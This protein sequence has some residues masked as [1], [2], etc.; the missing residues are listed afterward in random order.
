M[1][2]WPLGLFIGRRGIC[3]LCLGISLLLSMEV[4]VGLCGNS[5]IQKRLCY[6]FLSVNKVEA[7]FL[8]PINLCVTTDVSIL[9]VYRVE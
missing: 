1:S 7:L 5:R 4:H 6:I 9:N 8:I 2:I 3:L